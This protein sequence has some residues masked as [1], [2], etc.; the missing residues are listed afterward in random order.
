MDMD[1]EADFR[2]SP[3]PSFVMRATYQIRPFFFSACY[4]SFFAPLSLLSKSLGT[5]HNVKHGKSGN[6]PV[7]LETGFGGRLARLRDTLIGP[8]VAHLTNTAQCFRA[9]RVPCL[10]G[11]ALGLLF[12]PIAPHE[13]QARNDFATL[14]RW[15]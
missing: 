5:L 15:N 10:V 14:P 7:W 6:T 2:P 12:L 11:P 8:K 9:S 4:V 1:I 3:F 13:R